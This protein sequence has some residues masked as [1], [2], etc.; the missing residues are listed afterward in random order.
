MIKYKHPIDAYHRST[1]IR[2]IGQHEAGHYIAARVLGFK[3]GSI[4]LTITDLLG[5]HSA[6]SEIT[7]AC[8]L[9][10]DECIIDYLERRVTVLYSGAL[11]ES[12]SNDIIDNDYALNCIRAGGGKS[13]YDKA[14]E[15]IQ[16]LRNIKYPNDIAEEEIQSSLDSIDS[17]IWNKA[18]EIIQAEHKIIEGIGLRLAS[19][20]QHIG[21]PFVLSS[22]EL[23]SL[24]IIKERF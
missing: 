10:G 21:E 5:G 6:G 9:S 2:R 4:S 19:E 8:P 15:L 20:V 16:L 23:D 11:A 3:V 18:A 13:D 14:R 24:P 17:Y 7:P 1:S 12:L 22:D